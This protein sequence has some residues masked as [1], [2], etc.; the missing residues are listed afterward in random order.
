MR[1]K[2]INK[3][4]QLIAFLTNILHMKND[5]EHMTTNFPKTN[6]HCNKVLI[7]NTA[8]SDINDF[9]QRDNKVN[10]RTNVSLDNKDTETSDIIRNNRENSTKYIRK[11]THLQDFPLKFVPTFD[12]HI[13]DAANESSVSSSSSM[14]P[15]KQLN[16]TNGSNIKTKIKAFVYNSRDGLASYNKTIRVVTNLRVPQDASHTSVARL[17]TT[18]DHVFSTACTDAFL[19]IRPPHDNT[20]IISSSESIDD[21]STTD[22]DDNNNVEMNYS[23]DIKNDPPKICT[24]REAYLPINTNSPKVAS[25][26]R[27]Y[28][29]KSSTKYGSPDMIGITETGNNVENELVNVD[30]EHVFPPMPIPTDSHDHVYN[31]IT[32]QMVDALIRSINN[33][34]TSNGISDLI[35]SSGIS[36]V[37]SVDN[38][39]TLHAFSIQL[40]TPPTNIISIN[41]C[42][43]IVFLGHISIF[44]SN[45]P[46][47]IIL[48]ISP[49]DII[50]IRSNKTN[51]NSKTK[52]QNSNVSSTSHSNITPG[53]NFNFSVFYQKNLH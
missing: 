25:E 8:S 38:V 1:K 44:V 26:V 4:N 33:N 20:L 21:V 19:K 35:L 13:A 18:D 40:A 22:F 14:I 17:S 11:G 7:A 3:D 15:K 52:N 5:S 29:M 37:T 39:T 46:P 27:K 48:H 31:S 30:P 47:Q 53:N 16:E 36:K 50:F 34:D 2:N 6:E 49:N 10:D 24:E 45:N 32:D 23:N 51:D 28:P 9:E 42:I 43:I 41:N 12:K